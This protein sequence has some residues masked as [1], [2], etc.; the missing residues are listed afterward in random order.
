MLKNM[1]NIKNIKENI[2]NFLKKRAVIYGLLI[3]LAA[4]WSYYIYNIFKTNTDILQA[5]Y[6]PDQLFQPNTD[7]S[8]HLEEKKREILQS[9]NEELTQESQSQIQEDTRLLARLDNLWNSLQEYVSPFKKKRPAVETGP[10]TTAEKNPENSSSEDTSNNSLDTKKV[11]QNVLSLVSN[12]NIIKNASIINSNSS[13]SSAKSIPSFS[14]NKYGLSD[15]P[16]NDWLFR[17]HSLE[18]FHTRSII[19]RI[20]R[21]LALEGTWEATSVGKGDPSPLFDF[22][23]RSVQAL[24]FLQDS[25]LPSAFMDSGKIDSGYPLSYGIGLNLKLSPDL[26]LRFDYSHEYSNDHFIEYKGNWESSL[27][28]DYLRSSQT[29]DPL[30]V[31][32]FFF[33]FRYLYQDKKTLIPFHTGFFYATNMIAES[34]YSKVSMGFSIGGGIKRKGVRLGIAYRLRFWESPND[35]LIHQEERDYNQN[36]S[37]QLLFSLAF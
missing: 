36:V 8:T 20:H 27:L 4:P 10:L 16:E 14:Y 23:F 11:L 18:G 35:K 13:P 2:P 17:F 15:S 3:L 37:N 24:A 6:R 1:N 5:L 34:L 7:I 9:L 29:K 32:N 21:K 19:W 22:G 33:G 26:N 25:P 28:T 31:H 12:K 30:S